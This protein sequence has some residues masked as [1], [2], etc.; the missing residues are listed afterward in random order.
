MAKIKKMQAGGKTPAKKPTYKNLPMGVQLEQE[1]T[2]GYRK[3]DTKP[4]KQDSAT[5]KQGYDRGLKGGK[6]Y[7]GER[8]ISRMGRWEGQNEKPKPKVA[9]KKK[10]QAGG[11]VKSTKRVGPVDPNGAYTKVQERTLASKK[12]PKVPLK[13][14]KPLGATKMKNGGKAKKK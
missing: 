8:P 10:M 12:A 4:T 1:E 14:D 13:K 9:P 6:A 7:P 5:Y 2:S 11:V 3:P